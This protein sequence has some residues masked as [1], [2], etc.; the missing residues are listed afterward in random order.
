LSR[1]YVILG[2][3]IAGQTAAED[4]RKLDAGKWFA[5]DFAGQRIPTLDEVLAW[6]RGR[7]YLAIEI[8][9]GPVFYEQIEAKLVELLARHRMRERA[10]IIS[11]DHRALGRL[12]ALDPG[13]LTGVVYTCRPADPV[14]LARG[15]GARVLEPHWGLVTPEG[16]AAAHAAGLKVNAWATSERRVL[17]RLLRAGVDGVTTD[18]PDVLVE[19]LAEA[20]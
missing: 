5:A 7:T 14:A 4:L 1:R 10:L 6:A 16:V 8:K 9:N 17:R 20:G 15:A 19:L 2:N 11:F 18:H 13:L 3:G 12:R